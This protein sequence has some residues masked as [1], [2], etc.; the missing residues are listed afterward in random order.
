[1]P[2]LIPAAMNI[3]DYK[4][5]ALPPLLM[6]ESWGRVSAD[7]IAAAGKNGKRGCG[8]GH[9]TR[10]EVILPAERSAD[11]APDLA[12][13]LWIVVGYENGYLLACVCCVAL[14]KPCWKLPRL[15][16]MQMLPRLIW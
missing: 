1:M 5:D 6:V 15:C 9:E 4:R 10:V 8:D 7:R 13:T 2:L 11:M 12:D 16:A 14:P 3:M